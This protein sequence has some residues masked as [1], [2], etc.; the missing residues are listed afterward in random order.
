V[1]RSFVV[2][3]RVLLRLGIETLLERSQQRAT[4]SELRT[5]ER[6]RRSGGAQSRARSARARG[7]VAA[8]E[9]RDGA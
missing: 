3:E 7:A 8:R 6:D 5:S 1:K 4:P 2:N 9:P